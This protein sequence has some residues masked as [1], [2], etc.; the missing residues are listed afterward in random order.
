MI[1]PFFWKKKGEDVDVKGNELDEVTPTP[2][3]VRLEI[4]LNQCSKILVAMNLHMPAG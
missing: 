4:R 3:G 1:E 2:A